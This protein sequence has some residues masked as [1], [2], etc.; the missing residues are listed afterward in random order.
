MLAFLGTREPFYYQGAMVA[1]LTG[2]VMAL[3]AVLPGAIELC[4]M[5]PRSRMRANRRRYALVGLQV[6]TLF[7][8]SA[9]LLVAGWC[10]RAEVDGALVLDPT[11]PL[12]I[13]VIGLVVMVIAGALAWALATP[14]SGARA[15]SY[16]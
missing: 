13:A 8:I 15:S 1:N 7:G 16:H 6:T 11:I 2:V 12:A 10:G 9:G 5:P 4:G 14:R 3:A